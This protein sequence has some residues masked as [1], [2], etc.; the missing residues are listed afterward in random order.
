MALLEEVGGLTDSERTA[1]I[2]YLARLRQLC[3]D[4][5]LQVMLY[6]SKARGDSHPESD[7]D[8]FI[9]VQGELNGLKESLG[10]L[11]YAI[12]LEYGVVLSDFVVDER[13]YQWM[14]QYREPLLVEVEREGVELWKSKLAERSFVTGSQDTKR[15]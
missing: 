12:S 11:S 3:G 13:R 1:L 8:L 14:S 6:G 4:R 15:S 2:D 10:Q 5:L 7:I 9:V